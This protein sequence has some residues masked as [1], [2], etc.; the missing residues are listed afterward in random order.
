MENLRLSPDLN[1]PMLI[2]HESNISPAAR[3]LDC[4]EMS[5][6]FEASGARKD[7]Y[8]SKLSSTDRRADFMIRMW[9]IRDRDMDM[10]WM[11]TSNDAY[12]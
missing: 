12:I 11:S 6:C 1:G 10:D 4:G 9:L 5:C 7:A 8:L 3:R 2:F